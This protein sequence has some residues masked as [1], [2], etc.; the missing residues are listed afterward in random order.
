M[1]T[2]Q[3]KIGYARTST[4]DQNLDAQIVALKVAGCGMVRTEQRSGTSLE[5]WLEK[6][7][8]LN[9]LLTK[10]YF[11]ESSVCNNHCLGDFACPTL[12][13]TTPHP[14]F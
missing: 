8:R 10:L 5:N 6:G 1:N 12:E 11:S 3:T 14:S 4:T 2:Y 9:K 13:K 7:N